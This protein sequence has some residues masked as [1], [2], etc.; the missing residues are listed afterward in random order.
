[1]TRSIT[2]LAAIFMT[3][4]ILLPRQAMTQGEVGIGPDTPHPSAILDASSTT[5]GFL[6]P[7]MTQAQREVMVNPA[8]GLTIYNITFRCLQWWN[9]T[10]WHDGCG[11]NEYYPAGAVF[12]LG[13]PTTIVDVTNPITGKTWM[14]RNLGA[15]QVATSSTDASSY[16]DLYQWGRGADGHQ[17]RNSATTTTPSST[18]QPGHGNFIIATGSP[19]DWR[20]PQNGMLWQGVNGVNNPCP[21]GYR[22]PTDAELDAERTS[23]S[24][25]DAAGAYASPLKLPLAGIRISSNG[26][27]V[28]VG[29]AGLY[30][31]GAASGT[32]SHNL[33]FLSSEAFMQTDTRASGHAVR[34]L[35]D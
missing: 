17:C 35:K 4:M 14:D 5:K 21:T 29:L 20:N 34:C 22:L 30:W 25:N 2:I 27:H 11:N 15:R 13:N 12:C 24:S 26:S 23:W 9:G 28:S 3:A 32:Q 31:S 7:R 6:P 8:E 16:G 1:M 10:V 18:D 33:L 19:F